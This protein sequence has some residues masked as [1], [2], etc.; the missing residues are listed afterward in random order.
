[1][2][3]NLEGGHLLCQGGPGSSVWT[4]EDNCEKVVT[5]VNTASTSTS[6]VSVLADSSV[7]ASVRG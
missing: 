2:H 6:A 5:Y 3:G 1:M 4:S 7:G